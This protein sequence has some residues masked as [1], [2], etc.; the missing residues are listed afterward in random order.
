[1]FQF[2][3]YWIN[4]N[5]NITLIA[6]ITNISVSLYHNII[7]YNF[8]LDGQR[9]QNQILENHLPFALRSLSSQT[10]FFTIYTILFFNF[11]LL[12]ILFQQKFY[13]PSWFCLEKKKAQFMGGWLIP[14]LSGLEYDA[15]DFI[16]PLRMIILIG[17]WLLLWGI[18]TWLPWHEFLKL[19]N[20]KWCIILYHFEKPWTF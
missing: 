8:H 16:M 12:F 1:M 5:Y 14:K 2:I 7:I 13:S 11:N 9:F 18:N 20:K 4:H 6:I 10:C 17:D 3:I 19:Q 15:K